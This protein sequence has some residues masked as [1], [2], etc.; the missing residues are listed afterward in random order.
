[1]KSLLVMHNAVGGRRSQRAPVTV[2][3]ADDVTAGPNSVMWKIDSALRTPRQAY[4]CY[5]ADAL[6]AE[7]CYWLLA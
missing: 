4:R 1:M 6:A 7:D 5:D 2:L 3:L